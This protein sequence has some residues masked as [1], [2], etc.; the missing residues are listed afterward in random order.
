MMPFRFFYL[1][2]RCSVA[3]LFS[4]FI[5]TMTLGLIQPDNLRAVTRF[6]D[7]CETI[8][9]ATRSSLVS[10]SDESKPLPPPPP[11]KYCRCVHCRNMVDQ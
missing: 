2:W 7:Y 1:N 11:P 10:R 6:S 5:G 9:P 3:D 4:G 8:K